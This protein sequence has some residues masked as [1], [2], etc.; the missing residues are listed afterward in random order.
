MEAAE[1]SWIGDQVTL[2]FDAGD[3]P[4]RGLSLSAGS[5]GPG[6]LYHDARHVT[7]GQAV[8]LGGDFYG[9][10]GHPISTAPDPVA[11]FASAYESLIGSKPGETGSILAIMQKEINAV[12]A[13]ASGGHDPSTVYAQLGDTLS[14]QWNK[15]TGGGSLVSDWLPMGRYLA[16]AAENWD[17]F[18]ATAIAAY[19]AGHT[20]AT[21]Y[22]AGIKASAGT[23]AD[24]VSRLQHAYA[25]NAFADHFL[26]DL[27]SA[28]HLRV[29]RKELFEQVTTPL[30]GFSGS[31]GS[32]LARCMHDEDSLNG[33]RVHNAR[34]ETWV[35][36]GDK[37]L[38]DSVGQANAV[39]V[40]RAVQTSASEVWDSY[41]GA[42]PSTA[43]AALT[44]APDLARVSDVSTRE[45]SSPLFRLQ[46]GVVARRGDVTNRGDFSWTTDWWG[47]TTYSLLEAAGMLRSMHIIP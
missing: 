42:T 45:N 19:R 37:R 13:A 15:A 25:L 14:A 38:L 31:L 10:V 4:A 2:R 1:H 23:P 6:S 46:G 8:A 32:L 34:G 44:L 17:H 41:A 28:G 18:G 3:A 40:V 11:A 29:P 36:Y 30:P 27:F 7:Y 9:R 5:G 47:L 12:A 24:K 26:S 35:A 22:A 21:R 39:M 43:F 20:V 16:L 33:L